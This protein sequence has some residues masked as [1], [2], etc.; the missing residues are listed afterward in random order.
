[1]TPR[2]PTYVETAEVATADAWLDRAGFLIPLKLR[3]DPRDI[4]ASP[5]TPISEDDAAVAAAV[6][7]PDLSQPPLTKVRLKCR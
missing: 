6:Q 4:G 3:L 1:M 7:P 5:V 2:F